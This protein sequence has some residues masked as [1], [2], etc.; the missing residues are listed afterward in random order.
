MECKCKNA[1]KPFKKNILIVLKHDKNLF[2][3]NKYT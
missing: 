3:Y 2:L 1:N